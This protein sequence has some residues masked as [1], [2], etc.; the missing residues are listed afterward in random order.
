MLSGVNKYLKQEFSG[1]Q[2]WEV[3]YL[4]IC[5]GAIGVISV[6]LGDTAWGIASAVAG[7]LY[8][9]LAGKG[10]ISCYF[11]GIFNS[12]VYGYLAYSQKLYGDAM[13]NWCW[14]L[15]MMVV[16]IFC[17]RKKRDAESCV[18]K[19]KL[20]WQERGDLLLLCTAGILF[21][22]IILY[23][24]NG[25]QPAVD[26]TTTVLSIAAMILTVK[27]C[28]EQW[29]MWCIVNAVSVVMWLRVFMTMENG[30]ATLIWWC[31]M[32]ITGIIFFFQ[33]LS[34]MKRQEKLN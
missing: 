33:W 22:A 2:L 20:S 30:I 14:Y 4:I 1:W 21:Y 29:L 10:K 3:I 31:I 26:S 18:I 11:F 19:N 23:F 27:R 6:S 12:A 32:L 7:T 25:S 17:W 5:T 34:D 13:L 28:V 8:T 15:P 16:G 9:L 24:L